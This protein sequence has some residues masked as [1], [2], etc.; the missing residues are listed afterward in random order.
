MHF[1]QILEFNKN[2]NVESFV[3]FFRRLKLLLVFQNI[4]FVLF[5]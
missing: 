2:Q 1:K 4:V 3:E 5:F